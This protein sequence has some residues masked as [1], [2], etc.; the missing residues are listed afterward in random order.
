[1]N[2]KYISTRFFFDDVV[3]LNEVKLTTAEVDK[4]SEL[5]FA[6]LTN[7]GLRNINGAYSFIS[8][9]DIEDNY[10]VCE[11]G[12]GVTDEDGNESSSWTAY[13]N[14]TTLTMS[15]SREEQD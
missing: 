11:C 13:F 6:I 9:Y 7:N 3:L 5:E 12:Y 4:L 14:R 2:I 10:L 1:M 8:I 15:D